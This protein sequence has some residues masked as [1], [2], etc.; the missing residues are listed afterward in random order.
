MARNENKDLLKDITTTELDSGV[1][2]RDLFDEFY[3]EVQKQ[4]VILNEVRTVTLPR[5]KMR[6]PKLSVGERNRVFQEE[7]STVDKEDVSTTSV[8]MDAVKGAIYWS[9]SREAV[10]DVSDDAIADKVM[11]MMVNQFSVDTEELGF[12]GHEEENVTGEVL[13]E[14]EDG[15]E[16][17]ELQLDKAPIEPES[18]ELTY[19]YSSGTEGTIE[20]DGDGNLTG[21]AEGTIDYE[22]GY[23]DADFDEDPDDNEDIEADYDPI[24]FTT[25]NEGWFRKA[26]DGGA[27]V[28]E[29]DHEGFNID[30]MQSAIDK[31]P[32][33]Y[34]RNDPTLMINRKQWNSF[35]WDTVEQREA[36]GD[37]IIRGEADINPFGYDVI[38]SS[39]VPVHRALF[40][41]PENLIYGLHRDVEVATLTESDD[42]FDKDLYAK[43]KMNVRDDFQIEETDAV[44]VI[45]EMEI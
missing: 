15:T 13:G 23:I 22:T 20:D 39:V 36:L 27:E 24:T 32:P 43:Y 17:Y 1:L 18:L 19:K 14:T 4:S 45:D 10:E 28:V 3:Q 16:E 30:L 7:A 9:L 41:I 2:P 26:L 6:I 34:H 37:S 33:K 8:D 42:V 5:E 25:Q 29:A 12:I 40:T 38:A 44:V 35:L 31:L 21:D 11:D